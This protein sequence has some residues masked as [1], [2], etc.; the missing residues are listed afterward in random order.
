MSP[1]E[2]A[3]IQRLADY[4]IKLITKYDKSGNGLIKKTVYPNFLMDVFLQGT[5]GDDYSQYRHQ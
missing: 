2:D 1:E 4:L 3:S 5:F